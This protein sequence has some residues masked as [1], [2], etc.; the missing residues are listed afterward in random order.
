MKKIFYKDILLGIHLVSMEN[1][2]N[3]ITDPHHSLQMVTIKHPSKAIVKP[4]RHKPTKRTTDILQECL[5]VCKGKI[6]VDLFTPEGQLFEEIIV[7][8]G[9][10]FIT[11]NG[12]HGIH[13]IE[14]AEVYEIKN[15][16][17]AE[18]KELL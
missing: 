15:G 12:G 7:N 2:T 10:A 8:T 14:D 13:I 11:I 3:P 1:G 6:K 4:H 9:E 5:V 16:P 18:D 17:F